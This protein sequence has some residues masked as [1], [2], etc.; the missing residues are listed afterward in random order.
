[1]DKKLTANCPECGFI[2][3]SVVT[4]VFHMER[5]HGMELHLVYKMMEKEMPE[6]LEALRLESSQKRARR[7]AADAARS[8]KKK[9]PP[10]EDF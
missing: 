2:T 4:F 10:R 9:S 1:M 7:L 6:V 5:E 3:E 8:R